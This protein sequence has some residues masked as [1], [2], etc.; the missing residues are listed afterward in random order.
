MQITTF[1]TGTLCNQPKW[2]TGCIPQPMVKGFIRMYC[3]HI[4]RIPQAKVFEYDISNYVLTKTDGLGCR[5]TTSV[6][7]APSGLPSVS[8]EQPDSMQFEHNGQILITKVGGGLAPYR[9]I[10][11]MDEIISPFILGIG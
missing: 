8:N 10:L 1:P 6:R 11:V 4:Q 5:T 9:S 7:D 3:R 2:K